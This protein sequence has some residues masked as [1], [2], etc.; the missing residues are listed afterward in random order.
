MRSTDYK[1]AGM[2]PCHCHLVNSS[3][4]FRLQP[5]GHFLWEAIPPPHLVRS[6]GEAH[7]ISFPSSHLALQQFQVHFW[8][9]D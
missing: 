2:A 7:S 4:S 9:S 3:L 6:P 8:L 5:G 1:G